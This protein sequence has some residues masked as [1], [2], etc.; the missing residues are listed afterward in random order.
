MGRPIFYAQRRVGFGGRSFPCFK[1]RTM[2]HDAEAVLLVHLKQNS[3][4]ATEW[5]QR[6][7]LTYD[8]RVTGLGRIL[9]RSSIDELPQL[10]GVLQGHMSCVGP[11]PVLEQESKRYG[12]YWNDYVR[13]RPGLTGVWQVSG[14]NRL[15]YERRVSL[16]RWYV[17]KWSIWTD[18]AILVRTIPAVLRMDD[19]A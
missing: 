7:K 1:F 3:Q 18:L 2:V 19:T 12:S 17:R 14:R 15:T 16:D 13:A 9:R 5:G 4:A 11:R 6:Q 8:P 10:F